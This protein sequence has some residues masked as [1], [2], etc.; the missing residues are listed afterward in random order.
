MNQQ[1]DN[2]FGSVSAHMLSNVNLLPLTLIFGM[3][4]HLDLI[5]SLTIGQGVGSKVNMVKQ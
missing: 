1:A 2:A 5:W 3:R 4:V